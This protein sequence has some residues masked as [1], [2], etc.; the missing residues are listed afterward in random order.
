MA[1]EACNRGVPIRFTAEELHFFWHAADL[2]GLTFNDYMR[3]ELGLPY[4]DD[5]PAVAKRVALELERHSSPRPAKP[6]RRL[7][8]RSAADAR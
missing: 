8:R 2:A 5:L 3:G 4:E 1:N 6:R 7:W